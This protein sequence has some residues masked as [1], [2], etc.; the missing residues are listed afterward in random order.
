MSEIASLL[1]NDV[2]EKS[3]SYDKRKPIRIEPVKLR[4]Y[5]LCPSDLPRLQA[6]YMWR[7]HSVRRNTVRSRLFYPYL[8]LVRKMRI[9]LVKYFSCTITGTAPT[10]I[11]LDKRSSEAVLYL[12][13]RWEFHALQIARLTRHFLNVNLETETI[14]NSPRTCQRYTLSRSLEKSRFGNGHEFCSRGWANR[15]TS[16]A[17]LATVLGSIPTSS[18]TV[19]FEGRQ[20]KVKQCWKK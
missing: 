16:N 3:A 6:L 17:L 12:L 18:D 1:Y 9:D 8:L 11:C 15:L 10:Q 2:R 19:E 13:S 5:R 14:K 20:I 4:R 7:A